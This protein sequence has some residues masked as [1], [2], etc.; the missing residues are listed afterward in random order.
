MTQVDFYVLNNAPLAQAERFV[1]L[2][3]EK[4]FKKGHKIHVQTNNAEQTE[5]IDK[6]MWT[7]N[8]LSFLPHV[9]SG[10]ELQQ[11][12]PIHISHLDNSTTFNDV[13]INLKSEI[14]V[15]FGLFNR[16]A[17]IVADEPRL[18]QLARQR[19]RQYK[20]QGLEILSHDVNR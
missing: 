12:T 6:L 11:E 9:T 16:I 15:F 1:C 18:K 19:Y 10:D 7:Y 8:D 20:S 17:E 5:R 14:P 13:L 3:V 4:A 2:L